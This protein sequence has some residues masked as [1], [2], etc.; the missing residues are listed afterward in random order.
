MIICYAMQIDKSLQSINEK[1]HSAAANAGRSPE[2]IK[3]IAVSKTIELERVIEA[4]KAGALILGENKVQEA[5]DKI[6]NFE[7]QTSGLNVEWH[8]IGN[9]QKNKA[10]YAVKLFNLIHTVNDLSLAAELDRQA[11]KI[12]KI[13]RILV[14]VKLSE[15]TTKHGVLEKDLFDLLE[16]VSNMNNL[17]LDGLMTMPP[18]FDDAEKTR[19]YFRRLREIGD[20]AIQKGYS[21]NELSM[22]MS[23]D[24]EVAIEEGST[25]VRVGTALFGER[26]Y[27]A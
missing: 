14:Q 2:S 7:S 6:S 23:N 19:P 20:T 12:N 13:Q 11:E 22:G 27:T 8:L 4:V 21:I 24:F 1:I 10:K 3:L 5:R 18:F 26:T 15:E 17:K 9:L 16:K 25:M